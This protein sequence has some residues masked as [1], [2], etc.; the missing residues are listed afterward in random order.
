VAKG[1]TITTLVADGAITS[2]VEGTDR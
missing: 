2:T 1:D